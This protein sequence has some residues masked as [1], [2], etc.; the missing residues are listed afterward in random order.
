LETGGKLPDVIKFDQV[1]TSI[2]IRLNIRTV[3]PHGYKCL[4]C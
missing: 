1:Y 3:L 2:K 4:K